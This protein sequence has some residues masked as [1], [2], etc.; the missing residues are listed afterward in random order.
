MGAFVAFASASAYYPNVTTS[1]IYTS[2]DEIISTSPSTTLVTLT[3]TDNSGFASVTTSEALVSLATVTIND[4]ITTYTTWC[5]LTS[6]TDSLSLAASSEAYSTTELS[7]TAD[8]VSTQYPSTSSYTSASAVTTGVI[9]GTTTSTSTDNYGQ[10]SLVYITFESTYTSTVCPTCTRKHTGSSASETIKVEASSRDL[11][12]STFVDSATIEPEKYST[13]AKMDTETS[14]EVSSIG[15]FTSNL[16]L[17]TAQS[18]GITSSGLAVVSDTAAGNSN[19]YVATAFEESG[20]TAS[21]HETS[22]PITSEHDAT[23]TGP[24]TSTPVSTLLSMTTSVTLATT[25]DQGSSTITTSPALVSIATVTI[26]D[27]VTEYTTWC[28]LTDASAST[29]DKETVSTQSTASQEFASELPSIACTGVD[30]VESTTSAVN[31]ETLAPIVSDVQYSSV[32]SASI[33]S[34]SYDTPATYYSTDYESGNPTVSSGNPTVSSGKVV[35]STITTTE[36]GV[37]TEYTTWCPLTSDTTAQSNAASHTQL[38]SSTEALSSGEHSSTSIASASKMSYTTSISSNS[39]VSVTSCK[40]GN[41]ELSDSSTVSFESETSRTNWQSTDIYSGK[42]CTSGLCYTE[43]LTSSDQDTF[44]YVSSEYTQ[45][46]EVSVPTSIATYFSVN[47]KGSTTYGTSYATPSTVTTT[48]NGVVTEYTTWCPVT[49]IAT[50]TTSSRQT[51][52]LSTKVCS[53]N[54]CSSTL[55]TVTISDDSSTVPSSVSTTNKETNIGSSFVVSFASSTKDSSQQEIVSTSSVTASG[56]ESTTQS[57]VTPTSTILYS[58]STQAITQSETTS[59]VLSTITIT[60]NGIVT[61]Y[62]TWCPLSSTSTIDAKKSSSSVADSSVATPNSDS[63][64]HITPSS[65]SSSH[66]TPSSASSSHVTP[67]SASSNDVVTNVS[68]TVPTC[69]GSDGSCSTSTKAMTENTTPT[70]FTTTCE[71]K[72]CDVT[73][74][75]TSAF[76]ETPTTN[77]LDI[78]SVTPT[79]PASATTSET[80]SATTQ[81]PVTTDQDTTYETFSTFTVTTLVPTTIRATKSNGEEITIVSNTFSVVPTVTTITISSRISI[82]AT[83]TVSTTQISSPTESPGSSVTDEP[84]ILQEP[85]TAS[86]SV[87]ASSWAT[88]PLITTYQGSGSVNKN[89]FSGLM[90]IVLMMA[91]V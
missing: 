89:T 23:T 63:S 50:K 52:V 72:S 90:G 26:N 70:S 67:S 9:S 14:F 15:F 59:S 40:V 73:S 82:V 74:E 87:A 60:E 10:E 81:V 83:P 80:Y 91:L 45:N 37:V 86:S 11:A 27:V 8:Q 61:E 44:T 21:V 65:A 38:T 58:S 35:L 68:D 3:S 36:N 6:D 57:E 43:I 19:T 88:T 17:A 34:H 75:Y 22:T 79:T 51:T 42:S 71:G 66:V 64:S 24:P 18:T 69:T 29:F 41:C 12:S 46:S 77:N 49:S 47:A 7:L 54:V 16:D 76:V 28:P 85:K 2:S 84:S 62:T 30:C 32:S 20:H 78:S 25:D 31:P 5:P 53:E 56:F 33:H 4:V 48:E 39:G 13:S 55:V 1:D